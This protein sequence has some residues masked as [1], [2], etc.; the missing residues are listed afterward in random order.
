MLWKFIRPLGIITYTLLALTIL[1]RVFR[2]K[3]KYHKLT[4]I[5]TLVF[6]TLHFLV[7]LLSR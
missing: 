6:A 2:W 7:I 5:L 1:N 4:G 3:L